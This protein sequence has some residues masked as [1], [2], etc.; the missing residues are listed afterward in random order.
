MFST[1]KTICQERVFDQ[2]KS[3]WASSARKDIVNKCQVKALREAV[4]KKVG[5]DECFL[6]REE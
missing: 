6:K 4:V 1:E 3:K 5:L 2:L